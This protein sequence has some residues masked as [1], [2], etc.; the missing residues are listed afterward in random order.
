M[1]PDDST[2]RYHLH[3]SVKSPPSP[4]HEPLARLL[5][6]AA[7]RGA[8]AP[9]LALDPADP[10]RFRTAA[11][12]SPLEPIITLPQHLLM[13][14]GTALN[15][16]T[17]GPAFRALRAEMASASAARPVDSSPAANPAPDPCIGAE[18]REA[19]AP[20]AA[21]PYSYWDRGGLSDREL[22]CMLLI[23]E[24][25][26]SAASDWAPY[27]DI[28]P[29]SYDDPAWWDASSLELLRGTRISRAVVAYRPGLERL[30]AAMK[31]LLEIHSR[32][33]AERALAEAVV[34][35]ADGSLSERGA[36]ASSP[37]DPDPL[38]LLQEWA[39]SLEAARW[40]RSAVWSRSFTVR[41]LRADGGASCRPTEDGGRE[42]ES[43]IAHPVEMVQERRLHVCQVPVL[44]MIDHVEGCQAVWHTGP[45]GTDDFMWM[46]RE[47]VQ[48][49]A[50]LGNN[51]GSKDN[52]ELLLA[53]GFVLRPNR[54]DYV[55]LT[56][57]RGGGGGGGTQDGEVAEAE[58]QVVAVEEQVEGVQTAAE[59]IQRRLVA[60]AAGLPSELRLTLDEPMPEQ[61]LQATR[62]ALCSGARLYFAASEALAAQTA[63]FHRQTRAPLHTGDSKTHAVDPTF[64]RY[65]PAIGERDA[66]GTT[67]AI[68]S[69]TE[70][71][72]TTTTRTTP[73]SRDEMLS[74][75]SELLQPYDA[76]SELRVLGTI[77]QQLESRL[78]ALI[79]SDQEACG[80]LGLKP[81]PSQSS[82]PSTSQ[83]PPGYAPENSLAPTPL[84]PP[85]SSA[86]PFGCVLQCPRL[87]LP[88]NWW[89]GVY[90]D[91]DGGNGD[92]TGKLPAVPEGEPGRGDMND[93]PV[94]VEAAEAAAAAAATDGG[95]VSMR[96]R[97]FSR[98]LHESEAAA[99]WL[100]LGRHARMALTVV[101]G[102]RAVLTAALWQAQQQ[103]AAVLRTTCAIAAI[104]SLCSE[105]ILHAPRISS[106]GTPSLE[107]LLAP[108]EYQQGQQHRPG[109]AAQAAADLGDIGP[110][111]SDSRGGGGGGRK[112][113]LL[114][115]GV[116]VRVQR[117]VTAGGEVM[118]LPLDH[119]LSATSSELLVA[120]LVLLATTHI[121]PQQLQP[122]LPSFPHGQQQ[123]H[124]HHHHHQQQQQQQQEQELDRLS[125][126]G[127]ACAESREGQ[128]RQQHV[129]AGG[130]GEGAVAEKRVQW[131]SEP[132]SNPT[133]LL[134][135]LLRYVGPA[136]PVRLMLPPPPPSA[137]QHSGG[138]ECGGGGPDESRED[139]GDLY[140]LQCLKLLEGTPAGSE[141]ESTAMELQDDFNNFRRHLPSLS[142]GLHLSK[143]RFPS[144]PAAA[145]GAATPAEEAAIMD[146]TPRSAAVQ[147]FLSAQPQ[148]AFW[149]YCWAREVVERCS[150]E[151]E[152][153]QGKVE[154]PSVQSDLQD[155][156]KQ[157]QQ[158]QQQRLHLVVPQ[159]WPLP[160]PPLVPCTPQ[161]VRSCS[162]QCCGSSASL[163]QTQTP[164]HLD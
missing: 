53:Y 82:S 21:V 38:L 127:A 139:G 93:Y 77:V 4:A 26:R 65:E 46:R 110:R 78:A 124:H 36:A 3:S 30:V 75:I 57:A 154:G 62:I 16:P 15:D 161:P 1:T 103:M 143:P 160:K 9:K 14:A 66:D 84:P 68:P 112:S 106:C 126:G 145:V 158:Q 163:D 33:H 6:W 22:L 7:E 19:S 29:E 27:I 130:G 153:V 13:H 135:Q 123:Q 50:V 37:G 122:P 155:H 108:H 109:G 164:I 49:G 51:Y 87:L 73:R 60:A 69:D 157:G 152:A 133:L 138:G 12:T 149:L 70:A 39:C 137:P 2:I 34:D 56:V 91:S 140:G 146:D 150:V 100:G 141:Y 151:L 94:A 148:S 17:Y 80:I 107:L 79:G 64:S 113:M 118:R 136:P 147:S 8:V 24:R 47:E 72:S 55:S 117:F 35:P 83:L 116:A 114:P 18:P 43:G 159:L 125:L 58:G 67:A 115:Y 44:D 99:E 119:C 28:L 89:A 144:H 5:V 40:A 74:A 20:A 48:P 52:Q 31:R 96:H 97:C 76:P 95:R 10:R 162:Q 42:V 98:W 102:Q 63:Q 54:H 120:R 32:V 128:Q 86:E 104:P 85:G 101:N 131:W 61:L 121:G 90:G 132:Y 81:P 25:A 59:A 156:D 105:T 41:G 45:C 88:S 92:G 111:A 134:Q 71:A 11:S 142:E 23:V 129:V